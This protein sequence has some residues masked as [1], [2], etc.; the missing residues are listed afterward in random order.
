ML[1]VGKIVLA[2]SVP[3]NVPPEVDKPEEG[4]FVRLAP[5]IAG[6]VEGKRASGIVPESRLLAFKEP[7]Y[8]ATEKSSVPS[9]S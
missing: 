1:A 5:L 7:V 4:R 9:E 6:R 3:V 8:E 2:F